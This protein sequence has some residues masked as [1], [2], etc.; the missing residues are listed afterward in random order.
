MSALFLF[1]GE[2]AADFEEKLKILLAI[3]RGMWYPILAIKGGPLSREQGR[4]SRIAGVPTIN[5]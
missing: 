5:C 2:S 4:R 3:R 1:A